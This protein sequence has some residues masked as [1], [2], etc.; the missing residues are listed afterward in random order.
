MGSPRP[1]TLGSSARSQLSGPGGG[2][3][4]PQSQCGGLGERGQCQVSGTR[5]WH[6]GV[7]LCPWGLVPMRGGSARAQ[8]QKVR[9]ARGGASPWGPIPAHVTGKGYCQ[10]PGPSSGTWGSDQPV[11]WPLATHLVHGTKTLSTTAI[12]LN[13]L[14]SKQWK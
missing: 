6:I 4:R 9:V 5:S 14:L 12:S 10:A 7:M 2:N 13:F 11:D 8:S 3:P 1:R